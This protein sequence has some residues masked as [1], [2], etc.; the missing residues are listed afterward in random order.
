M[1][2]LSFKFYFS[3]ADLYLMCL[4]SHWYLTEERTQLSLLSMLPPP[5]QSW[6]KEKL[7]SLQMKLV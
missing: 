4:D 6:K 3:L 1:N 7:D 5:G 2:A